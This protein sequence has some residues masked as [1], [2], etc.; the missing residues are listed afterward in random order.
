MLGLQGLDLGGTGGCASPQLT[1][2]DTVVVTI[3]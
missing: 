2:T 3:G 1:V